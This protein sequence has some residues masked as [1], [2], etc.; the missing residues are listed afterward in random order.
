MG[1][2]VYQFVQTEDYHHRITDV[3]N[4]GAPSHLVSTAKPLRDG[5]SGLLIQ[6]F[7]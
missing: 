1:S 5:Q 2:S 4:V 6:V 3:Q 7:S